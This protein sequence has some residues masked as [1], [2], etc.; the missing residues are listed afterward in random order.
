VKVRWELD[1]RAIPAGGEVVATLVVTGAINP[2]D[3]TRPDLKQLP[4][5]NDRFVITDAA[6]APP[7]ADAAEVRFSYRLRPRP[8]VGDPL[9]LL[10]G[11]LATTEVPVLKFA[12]YNPAAAAGREYSLVQTRDLRNHPDP[13]TFVVVQQPPP[14][15]PTVP[16][17]DPDHL[18]EI[19]TGEEVL[20]EPVRVPEWAW[21]ALLFA[22]PLA[23]YGWFAAWRHLYPDAARLA[24]IRSSRAA[25]RATDAIL[26]AGRT[27]DPAAALASALLTYLHTR[28][29][30]PVGAATPTEVRDA[31]AEHG[32]PAALC[33]DTAAFLRA[34]DAARF[35]PGAGREP[36][37]ADRAAVLVRR[38][39]AA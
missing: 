30:L 32:L 31:L 35:G 17:G 33:D 37:L 38:W 18:F 5:F 7:A 26:R 16:L 14:P 3:I 9:P 39:E 23:A 12:Y 36:T 2:L 20:G 10:S 15:V 34:C 21:I 28:F 22:G 25:R 13:M 8:G 6:G 11:N 27:P 24:K 19:A 4:E 1:R 29:P